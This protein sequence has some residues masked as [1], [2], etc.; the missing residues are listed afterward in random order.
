MRKQLTEGSFQKQKIKVIMLAESFYRNGIS[1]VIWNYSI[2]LNREKFE[3][4]VAAGSPVE[5]EYRQRFLE[6]GISF[7]DLPS[8]KRNTFLY[9]MRLY[10]VFK[11]GEYDILHVHGNSRNSSVELFI[12]WAAKIRVRIF[13]CH[14]TLCR[15]RILHRMLA[16]VFKRVCTDYFAC[17]KKAGDW[18]FGKGNYHVIFNGIDTEQFQYQENARRRIRESLHIGDELVIGHI[19]RMNY[20]KNQTYLLDIFRTIGRKRTDAVLLLVGRGPDYDTIKKMAAEHPYGNRIILYGE[21]DNAEELYSVMDI[22]VLPSRY[23]GLPVV[24]LEA[25]VSGLP[26]FVSDCV[27]HEADFGEIVWLS[28]DEKPDIWAEN[29]LKIKT[30]AKS[31]IGFCSVYEAQISEYSIKEN[32]GKLEEIYQNLYVKKQ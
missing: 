12:A 2:R 30:D 28:I 17:S 27:T 15:N 20:Q 32:T 18:I 11:K 6:A 4:T 31:R 25:Q 29:I 26:C 3:V 10:H 8:R 9:Y 22:F 19:G 7:I 23:E 21:T 14:N 16:P 1:S 5:D 24:L 13:H